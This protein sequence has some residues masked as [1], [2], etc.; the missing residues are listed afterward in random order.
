MNDYGTRPPEEPERPA[1]SG[2]SPELRVI[3]Q[4]EEES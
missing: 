1:V 4:H 3:H 2:R